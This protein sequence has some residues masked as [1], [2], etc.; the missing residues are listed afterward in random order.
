MLFK[1]RLF[2]I[3]KLV[4]NRRIIFFSFLLFVAGIIFFLTILSFLVPVVLSFVPLF[5]ERF[6]FS[7]LLGVQT[8]TSFLRIWKITSFT[9][10]QALLSALL[11]TVVGLIT[12]YFCTKKN[13][14][15]RKF[16]LSLANVPLC[17]PTIIMALAFIL[18]FGNNGI[19]NSFLKYLFNTDEPIVNFL[20]TLLGVIL[21]HTFYN[22]PIAMRTITQVWE[23]LNEDEEK[24]AELLGASKWRIFKTITLPALTNA[25]AASYLLIFLFCFFSFIIILLF[26]GLGITT[27]EVELYRTARISLN[28]NLAAKFSLIE[29]SITSFVI[30]IYA[31]LQKK[32]EGKNQYLK[33]KNKRTE[34]K[35]VLEKL[36]FIFINFMIFIF[37]IIPLFSIFLRSTYN[38]NYTSI[39]NKY[40]SFKAWKHVIQAPIFWQSLYTTIWVGLFTAFITIVTSLFFAYMIAFSSLKKIAPIIPYLPLVVSSVMLGFGWMLIKP[41]GNVAVLIFAQSAL[42]WPFAWT[43][44]QTSVLRI[45]KNIFNAAILFSQNKTDAF[46]RIIIPLCKRGIFS[47]F[48][49]VF[50]ISAGDASLPIILNLQKFQNLS[51]LLYDYSSSYRFS[52]SAVIA[53]IL[54]ILAGFVFFL[55][56]D[57]ISQNE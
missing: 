38:I 26:G 37:L 14:K 55:Q 31:N 35:G 46:F 57:G 21:I 11:S 42:S 23:Y 29:I 43:Q 10:W 3:S 17:V 19:L 22:F 9:I 56:D 20:Y 51:L 49:F 39:F 18:F 2:D 12:A 33:Q 53:V 36:I 28:M 34:L 7:H 54:S 41:N 25:I 45:P 40:F 6:N 16:L 50:S 52:E 44:I 48:A 1:N 15:G 13:F 47:A 24:A 4:T 30:F 27:L 5:S 8:Q 32:L